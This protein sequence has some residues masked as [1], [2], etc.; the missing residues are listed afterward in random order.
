[1]PAL[2]STMSGLQALKQCSRAGPSLA[3]YSWPLQPAGDGDLV[4]H[5]TAGPHVPR[6]QLTVVHVKNEQVSVPKAQL[7]PLDAVPL[8][9]SPESHVL[10]AFT[11]T[12]AVQF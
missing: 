8:E 3:R 1:M 10:F 9:T 11:F 12:C 7:V 6:P 4:V 5:A 2:Y